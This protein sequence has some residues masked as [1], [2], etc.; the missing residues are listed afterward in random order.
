[1]G[2]AVASHD[3]LD[4]LIARVLPL[5]T[6]LGERDGLE[7]RRWQDESG[8]RLTF[9]LRAGSVVDFLPS[10]AA[11]P[12]AILGPITV[13]NDDVSSAL[14]LDDKGEQM[15]T[16]AIEIEERGLL[17]EPMLA[18]GSASIVALGNAVTVHE[19]EVAF[20]NSRDSLLDPAADLDAP[21][22]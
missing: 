20:A 12:G 13:L 21:A 17:D 14:I 19:D 11:T 9:C 15:T 2:L 7:V 6:R 1:V 16:A 4:E 22:P 8:A 3:A 18:P 10:V 5:S